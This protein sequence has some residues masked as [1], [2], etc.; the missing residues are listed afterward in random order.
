MSKNILVSGF[1]VITVRLALNEIGYFKTEMQA[2][3]KIGNLNRA[4]LMMKAMQPFVDALH[5]AGYSIEQIFG[6]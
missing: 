3:Y 6:E 1:G 5:K 2:A 4:I